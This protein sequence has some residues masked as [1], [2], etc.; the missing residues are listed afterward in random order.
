MVSLNVKIF[1]LYIYSVDQNNSTI[2]LTFA[3][4]LMNHLSVTWM[5]TLQVKSQLIIQLYYGMN[6]LQN[7]FVEASLRNKMV[8]DSVVLFNLYIFCF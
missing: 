6:G 7:I 3:M 4:C 8:T 2:V 5:S 1:G